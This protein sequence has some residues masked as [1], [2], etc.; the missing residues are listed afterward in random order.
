MRKNRLGFTLMELLVVIAII[1]LLVT[2]MVPVM[3]KFMKGRGLSMAGNNIGGFFAF[4]RSEAMNTRQTHLIVCF[5]EETDISSDNSQFDNPVGPGM[6]LFRINP[7]ANPTINPEEEVVNFVRELDFEDNIGG[8]VQFTDRWE[9]E[10]QKGPIPIF[11]PDSVNSRFNG[12]YK[13]AVL[14]DGRLVI[15]DDKPGYIIDTGET[16]ALRTDL[17]LT[18]GDRFVYIDV[19]A[20]TGAVKRSAVMNREEVGETP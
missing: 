6:A 4:A 18:D 1:A 12:K 7:D 13:I 5:T 9:Q 10:S 2:V 19:N 8:A 11:L 20:A 17:A 14:A 15:P 16:K 3:L